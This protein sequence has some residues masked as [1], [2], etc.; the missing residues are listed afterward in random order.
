M[1]YDPGDDLREEHPR[2]RKKPDGTMESLTE[3][4][5]RVGQELYN[6]PPSP[7]RRKTWQEMQ[8]EP[9]FEDRL[10]R[11]FSAEPGVDG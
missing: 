11:I 5:E 8:R 2:P 3:F 7:T 10:E 1:S 9:S 6:L 4:I